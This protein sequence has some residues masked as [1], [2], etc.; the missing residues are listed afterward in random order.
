MADTKISAATAATVAAL[1][2]ELAINEAGT[3]LC[4]GSCTTTLPLNT[5]FMGPNVGMSNG[6]ANITVTT[7]A[8]GINRI[9]V[10]SPH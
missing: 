3:T 9:Y 10:E 8:P 4:D 1:A 7:V 2:N 6:T 5:A